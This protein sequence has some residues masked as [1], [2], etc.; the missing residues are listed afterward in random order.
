MYKP[1]VLI[2]ALLA[3]TAVILGAFAAHGLTK[4]L[5]PEK[6]D[7]FQKGVTY[8]FYHAFALLFVGLAYSILPNKSFEVSVPL[9]L[10]GVLFFSGTLYVYPLMEVKSINVPVWARLITPLGGTLMISG[11]VA[12]I[13]G[14]LKK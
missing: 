5:P 4:V 3:C 6:I 12:V 11:W 8:Q 13:L 10:L 7:V 9:F 14:L 1:A 2:G